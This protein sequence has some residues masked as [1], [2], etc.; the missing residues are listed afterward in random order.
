MKGGRCVSK[1]KF[2]RAIMVYD[3]VFPLLYT[4]ICL[5]KRGKIRNDQNSTNIGSRDR[6]ETQ[7]IAR[8]GYD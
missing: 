6:T 2:Q 3:L 8:K 1:I 7:T 4:N 5:K